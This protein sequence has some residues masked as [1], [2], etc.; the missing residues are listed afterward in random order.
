MNERKW[1]ESQLEAINDR[2][3][4]ILVFAAA[5][6]GKTAVLTERIIKLITDGAEPIDITRLLVVTFTKA[7]ASE[8]RERVGDALNKAMREHLNEKARLR[9]QKN[10]LPQAKISTIH[11]FCLD[12]IKNNFQ[13]LGISAKSRTSE[14][15]TFPRSSWK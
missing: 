10:L 1:T 9:R 12:L 13:K 2:S 15:N 8:I 7:A 11:S 5:G 3:D 6:S 14:R 4:T